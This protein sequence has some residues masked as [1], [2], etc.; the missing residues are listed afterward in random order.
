M[1]PA[2]VVNQVPTT[3]FFSEAGRR[4]EADDMH[5]TCRARRTYADMVPGESRQPVL[6]LAPTVRFLPVVAANTEP[7]IFCEHYS[8]NGTDCHGFTPAPTSLRSV[9]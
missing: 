9:A 5:V 8:C 2:D 4:A 7:C 1:H 6:T 3:N